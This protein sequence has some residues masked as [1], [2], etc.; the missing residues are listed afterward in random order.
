MA[1]TLD[2]SLII[3][4]CME[5]KKRKEIENSGYTAVFSGYTRA[6]DM[7]TSSVEGHL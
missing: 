3:C 7:Y 5:I 4:D 1:K 6:M 2:L